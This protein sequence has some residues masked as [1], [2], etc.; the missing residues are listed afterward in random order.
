MVRMKAV[1]RFSLMLVC[2]ILLSLVLTAN[3]A[4]GFANP[5]FEV[6]WKAGEAITPN[7]W[8]PLT[9]AKDGQQENYSDAPGGKRLVQY[10]DKGRM[11][12]NDPATGAVTSGLLATELL[13]GKIQ[14][15]NTTFEPRQSPAIPI[16]G[17]PDN[18]GPTY[19]AI[20]TKAASLLAQTSNQVGKAV[21]AN[22]SPAG[23]LAGGAPPADPATS[24]GAYDATTQ[25]NVSQAFADYRTKV[26]LANIGYAISEPFFATVKVAGQQRSVLIQIFERRVLTYTAANPPAFQVEMGNIGQHYYQW[27][28]PVAPPAPTSAS[29][30]PSAPAAPSPASSVAAPTPQPTTTPVTTTT[31]DGFQI[32]TYVSPST[33]ATTD[34]TTVYVRLTKDG[35]GVAGATMTTTWHLRGANVYCT[36]GPSAGDGVL[37]CSHVIE[38]AMPKV[39]VTIEI[40]ITY[41]DQLYTATATFT[42]KAGSF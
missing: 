37:S 14:V 1:R 33:P 21:S 36:F 29:T 13:Q 22:L 8:G 35:Q 23:D 30:T 19:A 38:K 41:K 10:F 15:G 3:A 20:A 40:F 28:S 2:V 11:E 25:H 5:A 27:R 12:L 26:G 17:D 18:P 32:T 42:P 34:I 24:L 9:I 31:P 4:S 39:L 6:Q 16:A 7:F